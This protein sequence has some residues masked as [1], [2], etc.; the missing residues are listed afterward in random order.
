MGLAGDHLLH[1][2]VG[3]EGCDREEGRHHR[4]D[5]CRV[6]PVVLPRVAVPV[7]RHVVSLLKALV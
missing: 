3:E 2:L 7:R 1:R 4:D 6:A 5:Q